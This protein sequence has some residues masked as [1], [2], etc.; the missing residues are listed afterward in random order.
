MNSE[1]SAGR[2]EIKK[3][4]T[5][6]ERKHCG[7]CGRPNRSMG[8]KRMSNRPMMNPRVVP[9][10]GEPGLF[11]TNVLLTSHRQAVIETHSVSEMN[12]RDET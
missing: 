2:V 4:E 3:T 1:L 10:V 12:V 9:L 8:D 7:S 6:L 5:G 11:L